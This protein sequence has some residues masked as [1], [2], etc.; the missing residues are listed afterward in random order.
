MKLFIQNANYVTNNS[1]NQ[2]RLKWKD[3]HVFTPEPTLNF[4][5]LICAA[6]TSLIDVRFTEVRYILYL[7]T[8]KKCDKWNNL[9]LT[10]FLLW[11]HYI[12]LQNEL[13]VCYWNTIRCWIKL[14]T[15]GMMT[16]KKIWIV[17][18]RYDN[19]GKFVIPEH[20]IEFLSLS[21]SFC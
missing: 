3:N 11:W 8:D 9:L 4:Y 5:F 16:Y 20:G 19:T 12:Y 2:R 17:W 6:D 10:L 21:N 1:N 15:Q 14:H 13:L 7:K 18:L